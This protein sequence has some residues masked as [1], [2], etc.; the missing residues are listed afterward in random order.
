V[1]SA[2]VFGI[3]HIYVTYQNAKWNYTCRWYLHSWMSLV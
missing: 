1:S 3:G 2:I